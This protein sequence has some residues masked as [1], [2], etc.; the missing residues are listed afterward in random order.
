MQV[1]NEEEWCNV[2]SQKV[3]L[4]LYIR[5]L[6]LVISPILGN[7]HMVTSSILGNSHNGQ[8]P[9]VADEHKGVTGL[10]LVHKMEAVIVL[11]FYLRN[12]QMNRTM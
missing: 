11:Y 9:K 1:K 3:L 7:S 4:F 6:S 2:V 8:S 12:V 10:S 5:N